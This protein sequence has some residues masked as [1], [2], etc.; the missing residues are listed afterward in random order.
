MGSE[1]GG[2]DVPS[3]EQRH[4]LVCTIGVRVSDSLASS[5]NAGPSTLGIWGEAHTEEREWK[6]LPLQMIASGNWSATC[7]NSMVRVPPW[8]VCSP[9]SRARGSKSGHRGNPGGWHVA[10]AGMAGTQL[11]KMSPCALRPCVCSLLNREQGQVMSH[12]FGFL[13]YV[14]C[15]YAYIIWHDINKSLQNQ[16][17]GW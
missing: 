15:N 1:P 10:G 16:R 2:Q 3:A 5:T 4:T 13:A 11:R 8:L 17:A 14:V 7:G 9:G 6:T 12:A